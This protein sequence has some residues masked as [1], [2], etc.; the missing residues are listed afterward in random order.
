MI[1]SMTLGGSLF[2]IGGTG[3]KPARRFILTGILGV[4]AYFSGF[5]VLSCVLYSITQTVTFT[6]PYGER[7]PYWGKALVFISYAIPSMILGFTIWQIITP[8]VC[9]LLFVLSNHKL[10]RKHFPWKVCEFIMGSLVAVTVST[11]IS[12][13][14]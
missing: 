12:L 1:L 13:S 9:F 5:P 3:W 14:Y 11:L 6:L 8:V 2:A 7:T 10:T 4:I